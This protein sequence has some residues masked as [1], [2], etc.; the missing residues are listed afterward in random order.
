MSTHLAIALSSLLACSGGCAP[1]SGD[2]EPVPTHSPRPIQIEIGVDDARWI[3]TGTTQW[4]AGEP[5][6]RAQRVVLDAGSVQIDTTLGEASW[7]GA[8][9]GTFDGQVRDRVLLP[10]TGSTFVSVEEGFIAVNPVSPTRWTFKAEG[11]VACTPD[12][13]SC[14]REPVVIDGW[15]QWSEPP[16][17]SCPLESAPFSMEYPLCYTPVTPLH[18]VVEAPPPAL[19]CDPVETG[20]SCCTQTY[21]PPPIGIPEH[22]KCTALAHGLPLPME[23]LALVASRDWVQDTWGVQS[24]QTTPCETP[25]HVEGFS[26]RLVVETG[27]SLGVFTYSLTTKSPCD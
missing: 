1:T 2:V 16:P 22:A 5:C 18:C 14:V 23:G 4:L 26:I 6:V 9:P 19:T 7:I 24:P 15:L 3:G 11:Q 25:G 8:L 27:E 21:G 17:L 20:V 10:G 13:V 12:A